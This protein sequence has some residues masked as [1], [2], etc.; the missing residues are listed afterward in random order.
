MNDVAWVFFLL[1]M[2]FVGLLKC[3]CRFY[4]KFGRRRIHILGKLT[5]KG[6]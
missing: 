2:W 4:E 6:L 1:M 5:T 3:M